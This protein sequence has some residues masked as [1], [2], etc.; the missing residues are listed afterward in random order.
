[1]A[2]ARFS[3]LLSLLAVGCTGDIGATSDGAGPDGPDLRGRRADGEP[4]PPVD[5]SLVVE[6]ECDDRSEDTSLS[7]LRRLSTPEVMASLRALVPEAAVE[8]NEVWLAALPTEVTRHSPGEFAADSTQAR[9]DATVEAVMR[10]A[11]T[12]AQDD[13]HL[14]AIGPACLRDAPDAGCVA[15]FVRDFAPRVLRRPLSDEEVAFYVESFEADEGITDE[16]QRVEVLLATL[17]TSPEFTHHVP[18]VQDGRLDRYAL[19]ARLSFSVTGAGPDDALMSAAGAG[20]LDSVEGRE[21]HA[22]R[23]LEGPAGRRFVRDLFERWLG[24][25]GEASPEKAADAAGVGA[26]GL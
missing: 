6:A 1:M 26:D 18:V 4:P 23:L 13:A 21:T 15:G 3:L 24:M 12:V 5:D 14:A 20:E 7:A 2:A 19:A 25:H 10:I 17:L 22:R 9:V 16:R 11:E 8:A